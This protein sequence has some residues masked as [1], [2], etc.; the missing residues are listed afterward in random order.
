MGGSS[1]SGQFWA[2][3]PAVSTSNDSH[4]LWASAASLLAMAATGVALNQDH[5]IEW[6]R[7]PVAAAEAPKKADDS[8]VKYRY[9]YLE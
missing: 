4:L 6:A 2:I 5:S 1:A 3:A 8:A 9:V 7:L